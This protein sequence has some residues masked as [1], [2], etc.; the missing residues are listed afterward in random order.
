MFEALGNA[1]RQEQEK[2]KR[3]QSWIRE[4]YKL[5]EKK[6]LLPQPFTE[7]HLVHEIPT[8]MSDI[9]HVAGIDGG[10]VSEA[11][12]GFDLALYRAVSAVFTGIGKEVKAEYIP[13]FDP[14]PQIFFSPS[15]P[16]RQEFNR[17]CT[18][19]RLYAEYEVAKLTI[20]RSKV[21][22]IFIDGKVS[23]LSSDFSKE[24]QSRLII[25]AE[26]DVK[27]IYNE[28]IQVAFD[29]KV[30]LCG[31]VKDSRSREVTK[32]LGS[33]IPN[34]TKSEGWDLEFMKMWPYHLGD[35]QDAV[36]ADTIL[37]QGQR[38]SW[39]ELSKPSW[40]ER[41]DIFL[42]TTLIKI[43]SSDEP[44][45]L[46]VLSETDA[47]Y[48]DGSK[49]IALAA[50]NILTNHGMPLALPTVILE[51]DERTKLSSAHLD[52]IIDQISLTL[53]IPREQLRKRRHFHSS[54]SN[55]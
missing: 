6:D 37:Q 35:L 41:D 49:R 27:R 2:L 18:L 38:T 33:V 54:L 7:G 52:E 42:Q 48:V 25:Q 50:L 28:L 53:G 4:F 10:I 3:I 32:A 36:F 12:T 29:K 13:H 40:M 16:S 9:T 34:L 17:I 43:L 44:L 39:V 26:R 14:E 8:T 22:V 45:R 11:M 21:A 46:E 20:E 15:L 23:P 24:S 30:L 51:A 55:L 1:I 19:M 5:I 31:V 47:D